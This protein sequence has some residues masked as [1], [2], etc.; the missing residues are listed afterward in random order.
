MAFDPDL[1]ARVRERLAR[2]RGAAERRM[3]GGVGFLLG[4]H[5]AVGVWGDAVVARL[6]PE[7]GEAALGEPHVRAFAPAGRP[8]R[9]W[10]LV[11]PEGVEEDDQLAGWVERAVGFVATLPAK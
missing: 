5:L 10:V 3:F 6:G 4:G 9:G 8:M 2:R 11:E 1:A 7:A